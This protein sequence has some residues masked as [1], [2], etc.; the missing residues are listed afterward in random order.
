MQMYKTKKTAKKTLLYNTH[1]EINR[2]KD[3]RNN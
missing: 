1:E 3:K 2:L